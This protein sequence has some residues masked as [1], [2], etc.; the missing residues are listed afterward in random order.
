MGSHREDRKGRTGLALAQDSRSLVN[1]SRRPLSL[2]ETSAFRFSV[3]DSGRRER[4]TIL[5][6]RSLFSLLANARLLGRRGSAVPSKA[7][8]DNLWSREETRA[9]DNGQN[10]NYFSTGV[11]HHAIASHNDLACVVF[12]KFGNDSARAWELS[13]AVYSLEYLQYRGIGIHLSI[14]RDVSMDTVQIGDGR[15]CPDNA[16]HFTN[17]RFTSSCGMTW[18]SSAARLPLAIFIRT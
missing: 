7:L 18:P 16:R 9:V 14:A 4:I 10:P 15:F 1:R 11:V 5:P 12:I 3:D 8:F 17:L 6:R 2:T 13:Q